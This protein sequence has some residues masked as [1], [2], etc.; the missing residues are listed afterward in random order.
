MIKVRLIVLVYI[1]RKNIDNIRTKYSLHLEMKRGRRYPK[2]FKL[3]KFYPV[4]EFNHGHTWSTVRGGLYVSCPERQ[5]H[6]MRGSR[7]FSGRSQ[8]ILLRSLLCCFG[9]RLVCCLK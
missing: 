4:N 3:M 9:K 5:H 6:L 7:A 8:V 2:R 1:E